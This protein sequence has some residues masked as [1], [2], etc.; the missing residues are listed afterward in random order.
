MSSV[1]LVELD[2]NLLNELCC[3]AENDS[4]DVFYPTHAFVKNGKVVGGCS[5]AAVAI[6]H[7]F[8]SKDMTGRDMFHSVKKMKSFGADLGYESFII[9]VLEESPLHKHMDKF[10]CKYLGDSKVFYGTCK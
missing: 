4:H 5:M 6:A 7:V 1:E 10:G 3:L 9:P 8:W 2:D